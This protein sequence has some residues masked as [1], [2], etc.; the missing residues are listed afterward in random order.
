M[1]NLL[2]PLDVIHL[3][4][5]F[6]YTDGGSE[7]PRHL[8]SDEAGVYVVVKSGYDEDGWYEVYCERL[9]HLGTISF[10][11]ECPP[12]AD[13]DNETTLH[14]DVPVIGHATRQ[15]IMNRPTA[16][17]EWGITYTQE[18]LDSTKHVMFWNTI[19]LEVVTH[20]EEVPDC[21]QTEQLIDL[22]HQNPGIKFGTRKPKIVS[23]Q[24]TPT[25]VAEWYHE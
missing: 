12:E 5:G 21:L 16:E 1:S 22:L 15:W 9:G 23:R 3:C 25:E 11:Q 4:T 2:K 19:E 10:L 17:Y 18:W 24:F 14:K 13:E 20:D 6:T 8:T 7:I